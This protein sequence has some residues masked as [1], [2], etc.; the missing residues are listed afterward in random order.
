MGQVG[1]EGE[2]AVSP[3]LRAWNVWLQLANWGVH[4]SW[5]IDNHQRG[6][7]GSR[8]EKAHQDESASAGSKL[9]PDG[10]F[11]ASPSCIWIILQFGLGNLQDPAVYIV[12]DERHA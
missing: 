6:K 3:P 4:E 12:L 7:V 2:E 9:I 1:D 5:P 10:R 8:Q 11:G